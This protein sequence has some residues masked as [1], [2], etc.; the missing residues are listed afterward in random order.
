MKSA[1]HC[2]KLCIEVFVLTH[3][4]DIETSHREPKKFGKQATCPLLLFSPEIIT[5]L[6][7]NMLEKVVAGKTR[8]FDSILFLTVQLSQKFHFNARNSLLI[9]MTPAGSLQ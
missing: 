5:M 3:E 1:G 8:T 2:V 6:F 4:F 9:T 7:R